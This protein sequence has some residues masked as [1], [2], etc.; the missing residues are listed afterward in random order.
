MH[1]PQH[2]GLPQAI[3]PGRTAAA[4]RKGGGSETGTLRCSTTVYSTKGKRKQ[5]ICSTHP[6]KSGG[7]REEREIVRGGT[8]KAFFRRHLISGSRPAFPSLPL[9]LL[10]VV[11]HHRSPHPQAQ[12]NNMNPATS[13]S[14]AAPK[15]WHPT[16]NHHVTPCSI[17]CPRCSVPPHPGLQL[18][19]RRSLEIPQRRLALQR[20]VCRAA[21]G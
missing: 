14:F 15:D 3:R 21:T 2:A 16:N 9:S 5:L 10:C 8:G 18:P 7:V 11:W 13:R 1:Q 19:L 4:T 12:K 20:D 6:Q 17:L